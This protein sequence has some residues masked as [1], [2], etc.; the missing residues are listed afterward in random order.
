MTQAVKDN[1][2]TFGVLLTLLVATAGV[3]FAAGNYPT[4][5][6]WQES[7]M[8]TV[9]SIEKLKSDVTTIKLEQ[10]QLKSAIDAINASQARSE[11]VQTE[12]RKTMG[13]LLLQNRER[14]GRRK[15]KR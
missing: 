15:I 10:V 11:K 12:I 14:Y 8:R 1:L 2:K 5:E 3:A 13:E 4:R 6:E 9:D 7:N